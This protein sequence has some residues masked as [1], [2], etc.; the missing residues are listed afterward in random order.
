MENKDV[1]IS[2]KAEEIKEATWLRNTLEKN[3]ISCWMAPE[4]IPGGSNYAVEIPRAIQGCKVFVLVLSKQAQSSPWIAKEL[5]RAINANKIVMPFMIENCQL[6][7]AFNFYLTNVQRYEAYESKA[8]AMGKM[9]AEIRAILGVTPTTEPAVEQKEVPKEVPKPKE[10]PKAD[11]K[12]KKSTKGYAKLEK[13]IKGMFWGTILL[14]IVFGFIYKDMLS[15]ILITAQEDGFSWF[16]LALQIPLMLTP[17]Y[18][19][20]YM[21]LEGFSTPFIAC[22]VC[23]AIWFIFGIFIFFLVLDD[24]IKSK[25]VKTVLTLLYTFAIWYASFGACHWFYTLPAFPAILLAIV[26]TLA[27]G[28]I[29]SFIFLVILVLFED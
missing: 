11:E 9:V 12:A 28:A 4:S 19:E 14:A 13:L 15:E 24:D 21:F 23:T 27:A 1:F 3:G 2:Y 6:D 10:S 8:A 18:S 20:S 25:L 7:D 17:F 22:T 26:S 5:D 29:V 16:D